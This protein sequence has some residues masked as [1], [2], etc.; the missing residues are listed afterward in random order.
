ML[1]LFSYSLLLTVKLCGFGK[2]KSSVMKKSTLPAQ[3]HCLPG[4]FTTLRMQGFVDMVPAVVTPI[5]QMEINS[6]EA[7]RPC[8]NFQN[9]EEARVKLTLSCLSKQT[10]SF[11]AS[12]VKNQ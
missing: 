5:L 12:L 11:M 2:G 8:L 1:F 10:F 7:A 3:H 6:E 4:R 9:P